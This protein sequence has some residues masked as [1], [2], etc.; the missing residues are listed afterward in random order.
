MVAE[1][2]ERARRCDG[3]AAL[4]H[5]AH[6][7]AETERAG[8]VHHADSLAQPSALRELDVHA[9]PALGADRDVSKRVAVL[10]DV[11]GKG[12]A[13]AQLR[14]RRVSRRQR[15]LDVL[16]A[17]LLELR[18]RVERLVERPV[19]VHVDLKRERRCL[20]NGADAL[21][22]EAVA[23]PELQLETP[24]APFC[25]LALGALR[26]VV[27]IAEP[28]RERRRRAL[29]GDAHKLPD[30][31]AAELAAKI[32]K[33]GVERRLGGL[34]AGELG[35]ALAD[36]LEVE[37]VV[38]EQLAAFFEER[39]CRRDALAVVVLRRRLAAAR[40]SRCRQL[41]PHEVDLDVRRARDA[42]RR[43]QRQ[44]NGAVGDVH[45]K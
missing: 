42:K 22:V 35:K 34:L 12:R 3:E 36:C 5:A 27:G 10:V 43:R 44:G 40:D 39:D 19:L 14:S 25:R 30:R 8:R 1:A 7:H 23:S 28:D 17:E 32:V 13:P 33:R 29:P 9:V 2:C 45:R 16:D 21:H 20:A 4:D 37:W 31:S 11:D 41:H 38:S 24:E 18:D 26:H 15:L 6:H